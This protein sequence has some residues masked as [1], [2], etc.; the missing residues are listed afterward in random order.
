MSASTSSQEPGKRTTPNFMPRRSRSTQPPRSPRSAGSPAAA[1][2]SAAPATRRPRPARSASQRARSALPRS[3]APEARA[4]RPGPAGPVC[5]PWGGSGRAPSRRAFQPRLERLAGDPLVGVDV[6]LARPRDHVVG[7]RGGG[8]RLVPAR[9]G[10]PVAHVLLVEARLTMP[11]LV[12]VGRPEARRVGGEHLVAEHDRAVGAAA[13]LEL[14]V[15]EDDPALA[16]VRGAQLVYGYR[17][18][19]QLLEE[20]A[21]PD[22]LG[23]AIEVHVLVVVAHLGLGRRREDRLGELLG[24]LEPIRE[25]DPTDRAGRPVVLP[26]RPGDVA[27][28]DAFD[29]CH[30]QALD[31]HRAPAELLGH[32]GDRDQVVR[33]DVAGALEPEGRQPGQDLALVRDRRGVHDVVGRDPVRR[34]EQQPVLAYGVDIPHLPAGE[35]LE[36][37]SFAHGRDVTKGGRLLRVTLVRWVATTLA[38]TAI[39]AIRVSALTSSLS[40]HADHASVSSGW[41]SCT[42][43][44][45]ATPPRARPAYQGKKPSSAL[46]EDTYAKPSQASVSACRS[47]P[48]AAIN[49]IG[50]VSGSDNRTAQQITRQPPSSRASAPPSA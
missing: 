8:R 22:D 30:L 31:Q 37:G 23:R 17:Q 36:S 44:I 39:D 40:S 42:C 7:Q 45:F 26:A 28:N 49:P 48:S 12:A 38:S 43:P 1:R 21:V 50:S 13:E 20:L 34:H 29:R 25:L 18:P 27:A 11:G 15:G 9:A 35:V 46:K 2:T 19:P 47:E 4:P 5:P 33:A 14:R 10:R 32:V 3:Q 24:L 16:R 41:R 6:Q